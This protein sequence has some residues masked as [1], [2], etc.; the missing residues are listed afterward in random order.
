MIGGMVCLQIGRKGVER[1][2]SEFMLAGSLFLD[3]VEPFR[4]SLLDCGH[5]A[6]G[7]HGGICACRLSS[8]RRKVGCVGDSRL[9]ARKSLIGAIVE[10]PV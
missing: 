2:L 1:L 8:C 5:V 3:V 6:S 10:V 7:R 9:G 4:L